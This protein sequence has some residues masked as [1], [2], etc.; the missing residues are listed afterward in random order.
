MRDD[1]GDE[2]VLV[3]G[4]A[5]A[6]EVGRPAQVVMLDGIG[7]IEVGAPTKDYV[8][9]IP[10]EVRVEGALVIAVAERSGGVTST[11]G[12]PEDPAV[13]ASVPGLPDDQTDEPTYVVWAP[14]PSSVELAAF[15]SGRHRAW[16]RPL[17][18]ICAFPW[19]AGYSSEFTIVALDSDG[20]EVFRHGETW[21]IELSWPPPES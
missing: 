1:W 9:S 18:G 6:T 8:S 15:R 17:N 16:Q 10:P 20:T 2:I 3:D 5:D 11:I 19:P 14:L 4:L 13:L 7:R 21:E 12:H